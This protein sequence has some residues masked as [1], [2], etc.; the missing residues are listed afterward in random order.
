M[1][2]KQYAFVSDAA[3]REFKKLPLKIQ[4]R[5]LTDL[6]AIAKGTRPFSDFTTLTSVGPGAVELKKNGSPAYRCVYVAKY[7]NTVYVLHSFEKTTNG[8]DKKAMDLAA[9]RYS[10]IPKD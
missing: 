6:K 1:A 8:V 2:E 5:F 3:E 10:Q 9:K 4:L 7:N